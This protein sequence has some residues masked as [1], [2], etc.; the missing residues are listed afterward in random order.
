[1][2]TLTLGKQ[3]YKLVAQCMHTYGVV[4]SFNSLFEA[5]DSGIIRGY[6]IKKGAEN[7]QLNKA[8]GSNIIRRMVTTLLHL[9][10]PLE[11]SQ[12]HWYLGPVPSNGKAKKKVQSYSQSRSQIRL[13]VLEMSKKKE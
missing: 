3:I 12:V 6:K 11:L 9:L 2:K 5:N 8:D 10:Q 7:S 13:V 1:M 4:T